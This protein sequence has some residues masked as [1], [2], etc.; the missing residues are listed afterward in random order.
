MSANSPFSKAQADGV[1]DAVRTQ[2]ANIADHPIHEYTDKA[3]N[4]ANILIEKIGKMT[5][6]ELD[7][8]LHPLF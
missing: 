2:M 4:L 8:L 1:I 7:G 6:I 5:P 3:L